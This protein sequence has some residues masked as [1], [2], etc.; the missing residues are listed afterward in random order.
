[1]SLLDD[2]R[3]MRPGDPSGMLEAVLGLPTHAGEGYEL[4]LAAAD[5]PSAEGVTNVA[6]CGMGGSAVSGDVLRVLMADRLR[7]PVVVVR[8]PE[9]P[10]WVGPHTLVVASSYSGGTAETLSASE[11]AVR[12]GARIVAVTSG[13]ELGRR[14][15]ELAL[16]RAIV[17]GGFQ[18]RAAIG[19]LAFATLGA[20]ER[21][22]L[23][24]PMRGDVEACAAELRAIADQMAPGVPTSIN[25]AKQLAEAIGDRVPVI[26][27][28]DGIGA[29][30]AA[31]W[32]T[33]LNENAK[34]PA[35]ASALP[36]LDHNEVVGWS[37]G[38]GHGT[39]L[40]ALRHEGEH[41]D[42][43]VR[44][45]LSVAIAEEAGALAQEVWAR[46]RSAL[47]RLF[48]LVLVGDLTSTYLA[49]AREVD[50]TPVEAIARLKEALAQT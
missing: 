37:A 33:Q 35:W 5:L 30:A 31:R 23:L 27:G 34:V 1:V 3:S 32:K 10:E 13:G 11:E 50:P 17:P 38:Q 6:F 22:G 12:R 47:T 24:P 26:W 2:E 15:E 46:G 41:P 49:L 18:P 16:G 8:S 44:F 21:A 4:G 29:V 39:F 36:E 14:A 28:A 19:Y 48:S 20:L 45:P 43:A 25:P 7:V 42:V 40:V 9:L